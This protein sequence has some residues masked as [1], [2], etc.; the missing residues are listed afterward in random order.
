MLL[1]LVRRF[2]RPDREAEFLR[3]FAE[4]R[5][6]D[7]PDFLGETLTRIGM[8]PLP[9]GVPAVFTPSMDAIDYLNVARWRSLEAFER[10]FAAQLGAPGG[11]DPAIETRRAE[12]AVLTVE[13]RVSPADGVGG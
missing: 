5:P 2:A 13:E 10:Q 11:F 4:Q 1:V 8:G 3:A 9:A 6:A 7:N 12:M